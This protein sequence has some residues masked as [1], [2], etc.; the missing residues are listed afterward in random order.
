MLSSA[1]NRPQRIPLKS[2]T[3]T[4][5]DFPHKARI[6]KPARSIDHIAID[7]L[8]AAYAR[9]SASMTTVPDYEKPP[10]NPLG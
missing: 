4:Y 3:A 8:R 7:R 2:A 1:F 10:V 6:A 5:G 9:I